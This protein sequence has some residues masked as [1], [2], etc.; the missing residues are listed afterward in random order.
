[1]TNNEF[2]Q[3]VVEALENIPT[4][5]KDKLDNVDVTVEDWPTREQA[6]GRLLLGL[7]QGIPK[8]ARGVGYSLSLPDKITIFQG[9]IEMISRGDPERVKA[10]V[11][12]TV[13]HEIAHHFGISD[14]RLRELKG[15]V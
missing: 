11:M 1:M 4:F 9:P 2:E 13:E 8:T 6:Q 12:D 15:K 3:L 14:S 7:Y 5:F 10:V